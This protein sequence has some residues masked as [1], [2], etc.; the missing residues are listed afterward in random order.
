MEALAKFSEKVHSSSAPIEVTVDL[1]AVDTAKLL[2]FFDKLFDSVNGSTV[3]APF[4]KP[5]RCALTAKSPHIDFWNTAIP[6][7]QYMY[8]SSPNS[9]AKETPPS[10]KNWIF[11]IRRLQYIWNKLRKE[12]RFK[13]LVNRNFNQDPLENFFWC[14][15]SYAGRNVNPDCS[16]FTTS[17]K[18]LLV[19]NFVSQ[20]SVGL[21]CEEDDSVGALDTLKAFV[22]G[23]EITPYVRDI[24]KPIYSLL[25]V[26]TQIPEE[27]SFAYVAGY[28]SK[29][30]TRLCSCPQCKQ[31]MTTS[32]EISVH[33]LIVARQYSAK[34]LLL[35]STRFMAAF[36]QVFYYVMSEMPYV[37]V[38]FGIKS[39]LKAGVQNKFSEKLSVSFC[40]DHQR[41]I[42]TFFDIILVS[43]N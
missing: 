43:T 31:L 39:K 7:L 1:Q 16:S 30:I 37:I 25:P 32:D 27:Y 3:R 26:A 18:S 21:N 34:A 29:R 13:F 10:L 38:Q 36:K 14:I 4:G 9:N 23:S 35:P 42:D 41:L 2:A 40:E 17:F 19:N 24:R 5:L 15:R 6:I 28:V 20:H 12:G 33:A 22:E 11:S 8:F